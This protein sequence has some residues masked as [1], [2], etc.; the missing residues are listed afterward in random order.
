MREKW[1]DE[2]GETLVEVVAA[3]LIMTLAVLLLF[4]AVIVSIRIN[5][6]ARNLDK[7][8][9]TVL[10]AA[11]AQSTKITD[12]TI[13]PAGSKVTVKQVSPA[14]AGTALDAEVDFYGGEGALSYSYPHSAGP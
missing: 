13:V 5:K 12:N 11:E 8:F 2:R 4:G 7:D 14:P 1:R 6:S 10:N 9:Y 3:V